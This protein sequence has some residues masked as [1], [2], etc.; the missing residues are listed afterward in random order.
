M[1]WVTGGARGDPEVGSGAPLN[2]R[3]RGDSN[4]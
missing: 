1:T 3:R 4:L 2:T